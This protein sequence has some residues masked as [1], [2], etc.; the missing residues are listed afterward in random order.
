MKF[1]KYERD[2]K[3]EP[4]PRIEVV[5]II[6][7]RKKLKNGHKLAEA[8]VRV[9]GGPMVTRHIRINKNDREN[10]QQGQVS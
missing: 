4:A 1:N 3:P 2:R 7:E 8:I 5:K 9:N 10:N 6:S